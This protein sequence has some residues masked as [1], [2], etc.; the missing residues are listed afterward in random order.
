MANTIATG[1][2]SDSIARETLK[3]LADSLA[4]F[5][6]VVWRPSGKQVKKGQSLRLTVPTA[7]SA[8]DFGASGYA[9]ADQTLTAIDVAMDKHKFV[10]YGI[11]DGEQDASLVNLVQGFAETNAYALAQAIT[12]QVVGTTYSDLYEALHGTAGVTQVPAANKLTVTEANFGLD[13]LITVGKTMD[14]LGIPQLGRWGWLNPAYHAKLE[15]EVVQIGNSSVDVSGTFQE[16]RLGKVRGFDLYSCP[17]LTPWDVLDYA[18]AVFG[19]GDSF[20]IASAVPGL[21]EV[22][23]GGEISYVTEPNTGLTVQKRVNYDYTSATLNTVLTLYFGTK[24]A[25]PETLVVVA[26]E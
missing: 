1:L 18:S 13:D 16:G 26:S 15:Q 11:T 4:F 21:P 6:P 25:R 20:V 14:E 17:S 22:T 2:A 10:S 23:D 5:S 12:Y 9:N 19:S 24:L 3:A 7:V 8:Q